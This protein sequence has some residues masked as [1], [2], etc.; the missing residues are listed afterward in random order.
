P[1]LIMWYLHEP[2]GIGHKYGPFSNEVIKEIEYLDKLVGIFMQK[3]S[4]IPIGNQVNVIVLSDH[5]MG[6]ISQ[7]KQI[8]LDQLLKPEWISVMVGDNPFYNIK[9]NEGCTD[10]ILSIIATT[11]GVSAY[12]SDLIPARLNYGS[13]SRTLD[14][15]AF[16]DSS[17][18]LLTNSERAYY[19][20]G[21]HGYDNRNTDM[22]AIF[23]AYG[24]AFKENY[25]KTRF[26]NV[27]LYSLFCKILGL[28][29]AQNDG[30]IKDV[31]D[32][33]K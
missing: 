33:L 15:I 22:D 5:G 30:D 23:Y 21:T 3:L 20:K 19:S 29:E 9:A 32:M 10:S 18:S 1:Q 16:A 6:K 24:P 17:Y 8:F 2:D 13:N 26:I 12:K 31:D 11:K 4:S 28:K 7:E 25:K 14:I 27:S